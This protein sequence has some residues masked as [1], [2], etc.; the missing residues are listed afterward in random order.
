VERVV[1]SPWAFF[2]FL[3]VVIGFVTYIVLNM[4][5]KHWSKISALIL[6]VSPF[7]PWGLVLPTEGKTFLLFPVCFP[8]TL[9]WLIAG[10]FSIASEWRPERFKNL[11]YRLMLVCGL[12]S[13]T[14]W[15]GFLFFEANIASFIAGSAV[16]DVERYP[17]IL[18]SMMASLGL[19]ARGFYVMLRQ[20]GV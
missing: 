18:A 11:S 15:I 10:A 14:V 1:S 6:L 20:R 19:T 12:S 13:I 16:R 9:L 3:I 2:V 5:C 8:L 4:K 17:L 7:I